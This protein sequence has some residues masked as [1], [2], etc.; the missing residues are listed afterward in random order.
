MCK[1][2]NML[3][4]NSVTIATST[5]S[6]PEVSEPTNVLK[7]EYVTIDAH[8]SNSTTYKFHCDY[9]SPVNVKY[10]SDEE[11]VRR[12]KFITCTA[13]INNN[14]IITKPVREMEAYNEMNRRGIVTEFPK[15][16]PT[17]IP[18]VTVATK[19]VMFNATSSR[20]IDVSYQIEYAHCGSGFFMV[21]I[22]SVTF[23]VPNDASKIESYI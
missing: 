7:Y 10:I 17:E 13:V 11:N 9:Q 6:Y 1:E 15:A 3:N 22:A 18:F 16:V 4:M 5:Q 21:W 8:D 19:G 23:T 20:E 12:D 14:K 2:C